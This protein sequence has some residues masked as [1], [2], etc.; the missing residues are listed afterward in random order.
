MDPL[1]SYKYVCTRYLWFRSR[2]DK[3]WY[4]ALVT[5]I[6]ERVTF[7]CPDFGFSESVYMKDLRE[8]NKRLAPF[9]KK[10]S[11]LGKYV[12][13]VVAKLI[14]EYSATKIYI[15]PSQQKNCD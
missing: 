3:Y 9:I 15:F 8:I 7:W 4:R 14:G 13:L 6:S 10:N 11:Y 12:K 2:S 5:D 1:R